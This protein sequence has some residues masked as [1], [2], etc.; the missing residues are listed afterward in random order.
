MSPV[1]NA[2]VMV[3]PWFPD[4]R[5]RATGIAMT[6]SG[7]GNFV[8]AVAL[9]AIITHYDDAACDVAS[10]SVPPGADCDGW[11]WA[12]RYQAAASAAICIVASFMSARPKSTAK[13]VHLLRRLTMKRKED[14]IPPPHEAQSRGGGSSED[15]SA[16]APGT[17]PASLFGK[18]KPQ[19]ISTVA[20]LNTPCARIMS[21]YWFFAGCGYVNSA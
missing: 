6:G 15:M 10:N 8:Y 11:R 1:T 16:V 5:G 7:A 20:L 12:L 21:V 9:Q 17:S 18:D 4:M 19:Q 2:A 3:Q 13:T 14:G